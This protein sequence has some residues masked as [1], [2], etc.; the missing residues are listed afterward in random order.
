MTAPESIGPLDPS[1]D[2]GEDFAGGGIPD[3]DG[4]IHLRRKGE[5]AS[6]P[7][8]VR[9]GSGKRRRATKDGRGVAKKPAA[10]RKR[11]EGRKR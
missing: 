5:D 2:D 11:G 6:K 10:Q 3:E 4:W 7:R 9:S 1:D 8:V